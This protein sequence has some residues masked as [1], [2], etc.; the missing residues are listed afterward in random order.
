MANAKQHLILVHGR[1]RK[2]SR[3]ELQPLWHQALRRGI[4]RDHPKQLPKLDALATS[5]VYYGDL[6]QP[7]LDELGRTCDPQ[8]DLADLQT[9][10][11]ELAALDSTKQ[12]R[13]QHYYRM[14][15]RSGKSKLLANLTAPF[16]NTL[17]AEDPFIGKMAPELLAY[18]RDQ[19]FASE[20]RE[21]LLTVLRPALENG[22]DTLLLAHC[23]G[24]VVAFECL[25]LLSH[26]DPAPQHKLKVLLT[27]GSPLAS[28]AVR[29]G[30][31]GATRRVQE[32]YPRNVT[33]W[34]N[35]AA[36][37]DYVCHDMTVANDFDPMLGNRYISRLEDFGVFNLARRYGRP[38]PHNAL[39]YLIHP[40]TATLVADWLKGATRGSAV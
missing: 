1:G 17:R 23:M 28:D 37:D 36:E 6:L 15:R 12:F 5:F 39:G 24:S 16:A 22:E 26:R 34:F 14:K 2:P 27:V 38:N 40:R 35:V 20:V 4:E 31:L 13:S 19:S 8:L 30:M 18:R 7:V 21:R 11:A 9:A 3:E 32:R 25:W 33:H 29:K 10:L